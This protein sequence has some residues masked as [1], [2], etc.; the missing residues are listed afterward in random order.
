MRKALDSFSKLDSRNLVSEFEES[1][2]QSTHPL[3]LDLLTSF[4][5][6]KNNASQYKNISQLLSCYQTVSISEQ[7]PI[8]RLG[9][10]DHPLGL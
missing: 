1:T 5:S 9:G 7:N 2:H 6:L 4:A 10:I 3:T 8:W